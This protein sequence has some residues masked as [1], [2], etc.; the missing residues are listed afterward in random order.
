VRPVDLP[1]LGSFQELLAVVYGRY[2]DGYIGRLELVGRGPIVVLLWWNGSI[3][4]PEENTH[5]EKEPTPKS[6]D[7]QWDQKREGLTDVSVEDE[8]V[9][10]APAHGD[11]EK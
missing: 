4:K 8:D 9:G 1:V 2:N 6:N 11:D 10:D 5:A 7:S 3:Q